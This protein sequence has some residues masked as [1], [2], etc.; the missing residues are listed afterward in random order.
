MTRPPHLVIPGFPPP[1]SPASL[2]RH[3][4]LPSSVIPDPERG[5]TPSSFWPPDPKPIIPPSFRPPSRY[6]WAGRGNHHPPHPHPS[7][8]VPAKER[9]PVPRYGA[10]TLRRGA[11]TPKTVVPHQH[12]LPPY[13]RAGVGTSP[14]TPIRGRYPGD[15]RGNHHNRHPP[16]T[17]PYRRA[18]VTLYPDT[19]PQ[20]RG[21]GRTTRIRHKPRPPGP[22]TNVCRGGSWSLS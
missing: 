2:L 18:G 5:L 7:T 16:P 21:S 22:P 19:G 6:P 8:V 12:P 11:A 10:G 4:R 20:P 3:P 17:P 15:G 14:R 13:R 1:S 9:H